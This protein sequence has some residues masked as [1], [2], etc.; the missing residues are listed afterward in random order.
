MN[1]A[2][3]IFFPTMVA[4][5]VGVLITPTITHY[6]YK[7]QLWKKTSV[8]KTTDGR[9]ATISNKIHN[10][11][12]RKTPRM[13][14]IIVWGSVLI[15]IYLLYI[16]SIFIPNN[17]FKNVTFLSRKETWVPLFTLISASL[18]GLVDDFFVTRNKGT[19]IGG[20]LS[21]KKRILIVLCIGL[22]GGLWFYFK[23][24]MT[25]IH[26]PFDG[27]L[28]LGILFVPFFMIVMLAMYSGGIIDGVDGLAGGVFAILYAA[29]AVIAYADNQFNLAAFSI[30]IAGSLIVF[31]WFNIPPA[32][33]F[34][35]ETGTMGLTTT[36]TVIAF[37]TRSVLIL[38]ILALPLVLTILSDIIQLTS[39]KFRNGKK[40]FLV[41]P[42]HNHFLAKGWSR[43]KVTMR[44]WVF[45]FMCA[46][47]GI[48]IALI[49]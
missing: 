47:L 21:L 42:L 10:D 46:V 40:V 28:D 31:L 16:L 38:P 43:E 14:G 25:S 8:T 36:A 4:M 35:S 24:G 30:V 23:L 5:F 19:F 27:V 37:L 1:E 29:F 41:A 18:V 34:L 11:E 13:G 22:I 3:K 32:R 15:T 17:F 44:Y 7:W 39:K 2:I 45:A 6:L 26:I 48:V 20:G 49:S 12:I 9:D 33:F